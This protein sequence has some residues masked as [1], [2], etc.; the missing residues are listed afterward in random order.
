MRRRAKQV[1]SAEATGRA[2]EFWNN[3]YSQ[4]DYS[5]QIDRPVFER[6]MRHFGD[7]RGKVLLDIGC[8]LGASAFYFAEYGAEVIGIDSSRR[9]IDE[10]NAYCTLNGIK[11]VRGI[12]ASAMEI[13]QLGPA[14]LLFGSMI[15]HHIEPF[16]AFA[17]HAR[18]CLRSDGKAF[19]YENN[20][21]SR[22]LVWFRRR[23]VG[24]LWV[25]KYGDADEFPLSPQEV[26][27]L[28][29][30]FH[31]DIEYPEMFF[32]SLISPYLL[33][34]AG[35]GFFRAIDRLFYRHRW[36]LKYSYR[37]YIMLSGKSR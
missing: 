35:F 11:N 24:R 15:L 26:D 20:S 1:P 29:E 4:T 33:R 32:F 9:A 10:L 14:D 12:C 18:Q 27:Q 21:A 3:I 22:L 23:I 19:F 28:R 6:A 8:G 37:Q 13:S 5:R 25:P 30:Y 2:A 36:L 16:D 31:V 7:V 34:G 17:S